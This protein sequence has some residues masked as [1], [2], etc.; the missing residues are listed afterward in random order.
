MCVTG[1][2]FYPQ[3]NEVV[4][5]LEVNCALCTPRINEGFY[6]P[7][8]QA[9]G[10]TPQEYAA[11]AREFNQMMQRRSA[12]VAPKVFFWAPGL[13]ISVIVFAVLMGVFF[14]PESLKCTAANGVC[15]KSADEVVA[16]RHLLNGTTKETTEYNPPEKPTRASRVEIGDCCMFFCC[17]QHDK[18]V[19]RT[20]VNE[21]PY[22]DRTD[23]NTCVYEPDST[24]SRGLECNGCGTKNHKGNGPECG[25]RLA[26]EGH[27]DKGVGW[28]AAFI[29][30]VIGFVVTYFVLLL[31][32]LGCCNSLITDLDVIYRDWA[33]RGVTV[34]YLPKRSRYDAAKIVYRTP[35]Q[36]GMMAPAG[37][38]QMVPMQPNAQ[39][40]VAAPMYPQYPNQPP[41]YPAQ[42]AAIPPAVPAGGAPMS[43]VPATG[44]P[45][46]GPTPGMYGSDHT[47][48]MYGTNA[49]MYGQAQSGG[50][51]SSSASGG[52]IAH[53]Q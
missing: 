17:V 21:Y 19:P 48:D 33:V 16:R 24:T 1:G 50:A 34:Y 5:H 20:S 44:V 42:A 53:K 43:S 40:P 47:S 32:G 38:V 10:I 39:Y 22:F 26:G 11:K 41:P 51:S 28:P 45:V 36:P 9:A 18:N 7:R 49:S 25:V 52:P 4:A 14:V 37:A 3:P 35:V 13:L 15:S 31:R 27:H 2:M 23:G 12:H 30:F 46:S 29:I 8:F 6:D